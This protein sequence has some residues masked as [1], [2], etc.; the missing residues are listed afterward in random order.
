ML[1]IIIRITDDLDSYAG[2]MAVKLALRDG[3]SP[4]NFRREYTHRCAM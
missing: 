4:L 2:C 1:S 3:I